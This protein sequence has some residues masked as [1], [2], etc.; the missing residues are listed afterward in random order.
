MQTLEATTI[1]V[2]TFERPE[3]LARLLRSIQ[4]YYPAT[5][6]LIADDSRKPSAKTTRYITTYA[7]PY[8]SGL[9]AGRNLLVSKVT[10]P[11]MVLLD[12]DFIFTEATRLEVL[13]A[14]VKTGYDLVAGVVKDTRQIPFHIGD[15]IAINGQPT[16]KIRTAY[17]GPLIDCSFVPNFFL[18]KT[19]A[20]RAIGWTDKLKLAEHVDFFARAYGKLKI[21]YCTTVSVM[22]DRE[23]RSMFYRSMR[24][25]TTK[26]QAI[27]VQPHTLVRNSR[28][29]FSGR[30]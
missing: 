21:G 5:Q 11:Y 12:D 26:F 10:T 4:T 7:M 1:L 2:K 8:D 16:V 20:V 30:R 3:C 23:P 28:R 9:S 24:S 27:T 6:I 19:D 15:V 22:H 25:R 14:H 29:P 13:Q 18:A 17:T